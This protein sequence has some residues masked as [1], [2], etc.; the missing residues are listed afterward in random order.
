MAGG[1]GMERRRKMPTKI[2]FSVV[3]MTTIR[4]GCKE[5][6]FLPPNHPTLSYSN[7]SPHLTFPGGF[8]P[9][10]VFRNNQRRKEKFEKDVVEM[11]GVGGGQQR[12]A[13]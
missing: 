13:T 4:G 6:H 1:G 2:S 3:V 5:L 11:C 9:R 8:L 12:I 10:C 7:F